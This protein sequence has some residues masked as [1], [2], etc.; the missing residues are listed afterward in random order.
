MRLVRFVIIVML[1]SVAMA[2]AAP[3]INS[4]APQSGPAGTNVAI[5]G[6]GFGSA[7]GTSTV[8]FNGQSA[9][10]AKWTA[11]EIIVR[12]PTGA[13]SGDVVVTVDGVKSNAASFTVVS[14]H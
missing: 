2:S 1:V 11:T 4:I 14:A 5:A 13:K 8:T 9:T 7:R 10:A 12:V 6:T 3:S